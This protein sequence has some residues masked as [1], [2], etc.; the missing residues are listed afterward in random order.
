VKKTLGE[1]SPRVF[2]IEI[3]FRLGDKMIYKFNQNDIIY[4]VLK[5]HPKVRIT[6]SNGVAYYKN[7]FSVEAGSGNVAEGD[8]NLVP[9]GNCGDE[10]KLDFSC[11][12]NSM[13]VGVI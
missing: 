9:H 6:F 2:Y 12:D 1:K 10:P 5:V 7:T 4:N 11:P 8:L 13:Y 3:L